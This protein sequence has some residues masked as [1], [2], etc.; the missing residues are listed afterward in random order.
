MASKQEVSVNGTL[1]HV[2]YSPKG[3]VEGV[4]L[5]SERKPAQ[6]VFDRHDKSASL[7]LESLKKRQKVVVRAKRQESSPKRENHH[8]AYGYVRLISVD[9]R[10][11][12]KRK[13]VKGPTSSGLVA[14][15]NYARHGK[16]DGVVLDCGDFIHT[17]PA[18]LVALQLKLGDKVSAFGEARPLRVG[19]G[20]VV[21]A[22]RVNGKRVKA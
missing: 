13:D 21:E 5:D 3:S 1:R 4:L 6:I 22:V 9:G 19:V 15:F 2:I 16:P 17:K 8:G 11:A 14:R 18:G 20:R 12:I 7:D 10:K